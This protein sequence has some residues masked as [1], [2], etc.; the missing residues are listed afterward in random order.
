MPGVVDQ[1]VN[2]TEDRERAIYASGDRLLIAD[3]HDEPGHA[4]AAG[5]P[6]GGILNALLGPAGPGRPTGPGFGQRLAH[7]EAQATGTPGDERADSFEYRRGLCVRRLVSGA[8]LT[9]GQNGLTGVA[10]G[11]IDYDAELQLHHEVL[12]RAWGIQPRDHVLDIGCGSGQ[13]TRAAGRR[14]RQGGR[15]GS[16]SRRPRSSGPASSPRRRGK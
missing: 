8:D 6:G 12:R 14:P 7:G 4:G 3:V 2:A 13:T 9:S 11:A 5:D 1:Y 16:T 15:W 10:A